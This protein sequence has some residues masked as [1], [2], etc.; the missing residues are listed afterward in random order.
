MSV[1]AEFSVY[2]FF[3]DGTSECLLGYVPLK[4]AVLE[5]RRR[6]DFPAVR[7]GFVAR[8]IITDGGDFTVFEY[9]GGEVTWPAEFRGR[10]TNI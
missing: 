8:I 3:P 9:K 1:D 5:A 7:A 10:K 4:E 2:W 6:C